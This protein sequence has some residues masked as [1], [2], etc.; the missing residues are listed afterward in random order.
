MLRASVGRYRDDDALRATDRELVG[1]IAAEVLSV[2]GGHSRLVGARVTRWGGALPQYT[3]GHEE[4]VE[5]LRA[6]LPEGVAVAGA[7]YDGIGVPAVVASARR[8]AAGVGQWLGG[9]S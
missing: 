3:I 6:A 4:R 8:A 2:G 1:R 7:A 5:A 9:R